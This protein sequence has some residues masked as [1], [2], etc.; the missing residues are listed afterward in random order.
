MFVNKYTILN[1][2]LSATTGYDIN[3]P[4]SQNGG[5]VGQ[6]EVIESKFIENEVDK[7]VNIIYD[8]EKI[9]VLPRHDDGTTIKMV[10]DIVYKANLLE[11]KGNDLVSVSAATVSSINMLAIETS[12]AHNLKVNEKI[13]VLSPLNNIFNKDFTVKRLG[14][15]DGS[16]TDTVFVIE[17]AT[18]TASNI[19]LINATISKSSVKKKLNYWSDIGFDYN[20]FYFKK[21]SFTK[22]FL[23]LDFYDSDIATYQNLISFIT[24][25]PKFS[26]TD[27]SAA[28][29]GNVPD[30]TTY[31]VDFELGNTIINRDKNGEGFALYHFK[32]EIPPKILNAPKYLYM[33]ATFNNAKSGISKG[34]MSTSSPNLPIDELMLTTKDITTA[35]IPKNNL[36][37]RYIL[38]RDVDGYFYEID[39]NYSS[40]VSASSSSTSVVY[41]VELYEISTS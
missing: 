11:D 26:N 10:T 14:L 38:T 6:Q 19:T 34:L 40:N 2:E 30:P 29:Q 22:S 12:L 20:D 39:T 23:R 16:K 9:K 5:L 31:Q 13:V 41:N 7:A 36:Y 21:K 1:S 27:I 17:V 24:L 28:G 33:K 25:Y 18:P 3:V 15:D 8:Y 35:P 37:T 32:D 4:V